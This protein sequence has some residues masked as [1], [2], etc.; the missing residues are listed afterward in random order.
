MPID[1][2]R[3]VTGHDA[4]GQACVIED[5]RLPVSGRV[6]VWF[7]G[8]GLS[9]NDDTQAVTFHPTKLEPPPGGTT[10]RI[11]EAAPQTK[12]DT[13][14]FAEKR[15]KQRERFRSM[16][17]EH[18]L[19]ESSRHPNM[20]RSKTT[21][22]MYLLEGELTLILDTEEVALKA[23]DI[24]IQRGTAHAWV[25]RGAKTARWVMVMVDAEPLMGLPK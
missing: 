3:V 18:V 8:P 5:S 24:V 10:F 9:R 2:R 4:K 11:V 12:G 23:N 17:A 16:G 7:T 15:E 6:G 13:L 22:Y 14:S 20:H 25:N 1:V 19:V 21:D